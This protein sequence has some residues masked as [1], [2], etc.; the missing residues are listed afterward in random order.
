M[1]TSQKT[2]DGKETGVGLGWRI[3]KDEKGR[4]MFHHGGD[5]IGARAFILI[6]PD[7]G[8]AVM[9]L[10]NMTFARFAEADAAKFADIFMQ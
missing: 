5:S 2:A 10:S 1:F 7:Q 9:L 3:G 8:I 4:R 6:Y